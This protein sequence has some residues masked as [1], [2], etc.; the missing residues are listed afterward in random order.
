DFHEVE[1]LLP[2]QTLGVVRGHDTEHLALGADHSDLRDTDAIIGARARELA[3]TRIETT[4]TDGYLPPAGRDGALRWTISA[5]EAVDA[6]LRHAA[7]LVAC[8]RRI[9]ETKSG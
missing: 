6:T 8:R 2:S 3:L 5:A 9:H 4:P 1:V 7:G